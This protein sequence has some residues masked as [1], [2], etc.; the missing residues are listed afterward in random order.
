M[1]KWRGMINVPL[2]ADGTDQA[3]YL[4]KKLQFDCVYHDKLQRC[5]ETASYLSDILICSSGPEPWKM[6]TEFEGKEITEESLQEARRYILEGGVPPGG[7][8]FDYWY[9]KWVEWVRELARVRPPNMRV[10]IVT[11]NRNIQ[12][13]YATGPDG[14]DY[15]IYDCAGPDFCSVHEFHGLTF[16]RHGETSYGT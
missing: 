16:T 1:R 7:E 6:G 4:G 15:S 13:L 8:P 9:N 11:H 10:G 14:F 12:A 5:K 3:F 2:T